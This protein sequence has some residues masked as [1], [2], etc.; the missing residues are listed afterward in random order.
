MGDDENETVD[1]QSFLESLEFKKK[2]PHFEVSK[3]MEQVEPIFVQL[4]QKDLPHGAVRAISERSGLNYDTLRDWRKKLLVNAEWRPYRDR[5]ISKRALSVEQE[6]QLAEKIRRDY[7]L[8]DIFCPLAAVKQ[9]AHEV[10][11]EDVSWEAVVSEQDKDFKASHHWCKNFMKRNH[12]SLRRHHKKRRPATDDIFIAAFYEEMNDAFANVPRDR[13]INMDETFWRVLQS[14]ALTVADMGAETVSCTF[15][16]DEKEGFTAICSIDAAGNTLPCWV[17]AK[18]KTRRC[19]AKFRDNPQIRRL[20]EDGKLV[21]NHTTS[22]W[23]TREVAKQYVQ[24][25]ADRFDEPVVLVW[26][27]FAAHRHADVKAAADESNV[28][29]RFIPAGMTDRLQPLDRWI[30]G[31]LK[32][33]ARARF[34]RVWAQGQRPVDLCQAVLCLVDVWQSITC[35]EVLKAWSHITD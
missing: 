10:I 33:R 15:S 2:R 16:A 34:D 27:V 22:G 17:L 20:I 7:I 26:D 18:G 1:F 8:R 25:L 12:L 5:N 31:A 35:H 13:I 9:M 14:G 23:T 11:N 32:S 4:A 28:Q 3:M 6:A 29:L 30:F 19:E 21:L 24:W